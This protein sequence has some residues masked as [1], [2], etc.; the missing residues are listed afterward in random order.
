MGFFRMSQRELRRVEITAQASDGRITRKLAAET[1]HISERQVY[2]LVSRYRKDGESA[3][4]HSSRGCPSNRRFSQAKRDFI[5]GLVK[6]HYPDFGPTLAIEYL[7]LKHEINLNS[8]GDIGCSESEQASR[9][10]AIDL[11]LNAMRDAVPELER[12][13]RSAYGTLCPL[14]LIV[15]KSSEDTEFVG[16]YI[17]FLMSHTNR[18]TREIYA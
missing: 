14:L 3:L 6:E 17:D 16:V 11:F 12:V 8:L 9:L 5:L 1:L 13:P 18:K 2:R 15:E 10:Y 4:A 7:A